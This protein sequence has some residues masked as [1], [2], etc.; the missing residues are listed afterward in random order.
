MMAEKKGRFPIGHDRARSD[1][2]TTEKTDLYKVELQR[3]Q[4]KKD[5]EHKDEQI[6]NYQDTLAQLTSKVEEL[7]K[8]QLKKDEEIQKSKLIETQLRESLE[9]KEKQL[10]E[11]TKT[12]DELSSELAK[13]VDELCQETLKNEELVF[14]VA[15]QKGKLEEMEKYKT[16]VKQ[17]EDLVERIKLKETENA[18]YK[19]DFETERNDRQRIHNEYEEL[20]LKFEEFK[21]S[22][23]QLTELKS[24]QQSDSELARMKHMLD[25][26]EELLRS[27]GQEQASLKDQ[28]EIL[29]NECEGLKRAN[30]TLKEL[31]KGTKLYKN[32][33]ANQDQNTP[34]I[35]AIYKPSDNSQASTGV[36]DETDDSMKDLKPQLTAEEMAAL[37]KP[38]AVR[39]DSSHL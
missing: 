8:Q 33:A 9:E 6:K 30:E 34:H 19:Q 18:V 39:Q 3:D 20:K 27:Y 17:M 23:E 32:D 15:E 21:S 35:H 22:H 11:T 14:V 24:K 13:K 7:E 16:Q 10:A 28:L 26:K 4:L 38:E 25:N 12:V 31:V 1:T 37:F 2:S 29:K 36:N 5:C